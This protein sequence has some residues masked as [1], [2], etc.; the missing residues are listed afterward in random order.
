MDYVVLARKLRPMRFQ[1][2][3]GQET[4][5]RALKNAVRNGRTAHAYLFAGSRGVGKTSAARIL[6]K[7][8]NCLNPQDGEPCNACGN[9]EEI[10]RDAS[11]DV[12]EIDAASNRGID[13]IRELRENTKYTPAK[14]TYKTYIIDEVHMLTMESFNALLKTLE[15]PPPHIRFILATTAPHRIPETVLSRCQRFDFPRIGTQ[16]IVDY[17]GGVTAAE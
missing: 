5:V 3:V 4:V 8:I 2:L 11:P 9:C 12:H 6:T 7:A 1:D 14:C 17:L 15:E 10:T 16:L 13:N